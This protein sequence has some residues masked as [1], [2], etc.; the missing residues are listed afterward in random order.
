MAL[1]IMLY[2][3]KSTIGKRKIIFYNMHEFV[4]FTTP[5]TPL[6][7]FQR[8]LYNTVHNNNRLLNS[9]MFNMG[10]HCTIPYCIENPSWTR[11]HRHKYDFRLH[12]PDK[13]KK[14][15]CGHVS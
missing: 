12:K 11:L 7:A 6:A 14:I 2:K 4:V 15:R 5:H 10:G 1:E 3:Q 8:D 9:V 13:D